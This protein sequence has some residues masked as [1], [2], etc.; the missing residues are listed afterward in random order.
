MKWERLSIILTLSLT[1]IWIFPN[2]LTAEEGPSFLVTIEAQKYFLKRIAGP[3][4]K[5]FTLIPPGYDPHS[6]EPKAGDVKIM[7][8]TKAYF[9]IGLG[10]EKQW[11]KKVQAVSPKGKIFNMW[12]AE[13]GPGGSKGQTHDQD[14]HVWLSPS[15]GKE[16]ARNTF[17]AL[18]DMDPDNRSAY[19]RGLIACL[20]ELE[21]FKKTLEQRISGCNRKA[22]LTYHPAFGLFAEEFGLR[23]ISIERE[24]RE[25]KPKDLI[26][27]EDEIKKHGI[28][29]LLVQPGSPRSSQKAFAQRLGLSMKSVDPIVEGWMA[30]LEKVVSTL[31][32]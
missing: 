31:C 30:E 21:S 12:K 3:E 5:V 26:R 7:A 20:E 19:Q 24:G 15:L 23:Q 18:V 10:E 6:F 4:A 25:P 13:E 29:T 9:T 14:P 11:I 2:P 17:K 8:T 1:A 16:I 27:T 22:F 32:E 28:K